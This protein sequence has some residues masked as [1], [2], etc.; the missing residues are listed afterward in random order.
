VRPASP[1]SSS[2]VA[3]CYFDQT[4]ERKESQSAVIHPMIMKMTTKTIA[5]MHPQFRDCMKMPSLFTSGVLSVR[6]APQ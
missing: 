1:N 6:G 4:G 3:Q 2:F 5:M